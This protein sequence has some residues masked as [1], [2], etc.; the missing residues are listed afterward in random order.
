ML[1]D[2]S[3][4]LF[5]FLSSLIL[6]MKWV[7]KSSS[8]VLLAWSRF[9]KVGS[10]TPLY[11]LCQDKMN[12]MCTLNNH[13]W[14]FHV[15]FVFCGNLRILVCLWST[16]I[17]SQCAKKNMNLIYDLYVWQFIDLYGV[18]VA[19][20]SSFYGW[21]YVPHTAKTHSDSFLVVKLHKK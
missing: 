19:D 7:V 6:S 15:L 8:E 5:H 13:G 1:L 12:V 9:V 18:F 3:N 17:T 14:S 4:Y 16:N 2:G 20:V 10:D 11:H 21:A